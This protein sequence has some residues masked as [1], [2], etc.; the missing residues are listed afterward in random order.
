[1][2]AEPVPAGAPKPP[3]L[4]TLR[5]TQVAGAW[6]VGSLLLVCVTPVWILST[7]ILG[8]FGL[9]LSVPLL[10]VVAAGVL[11]MVARSTAGASPMTATGRGRG[12]DRARGGRRGRRPADE[13]VRI[14]RPGERVR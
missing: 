8:E 13:R 7:L 14:R 10:V 3:S 11:A 1:M 5:V 4:V 12:R 9:V 2:D 6:I